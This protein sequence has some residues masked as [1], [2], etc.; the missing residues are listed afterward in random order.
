M[1]RSR[2]ERRIIPFGNHN[3]FDVGVKAFKLGDVRLESERLTRF[4]NDLLAIARGDSGLT[5]EKKTPAEWTVAQHDGKI[6]LE[7]EPAKS[8]TAWVQLPLYS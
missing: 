3:N 8:T 6:W 7:S 2:L 1:H 4:V 5:L